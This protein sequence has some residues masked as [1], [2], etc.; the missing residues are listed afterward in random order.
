[1]SQ[2]PQWL[3]GVILKV[4]VKKLFVRRVNQISNPDISYNGYPTGDAA[5]ADNARVIRD[6]RF[7]M[8]KIGD[9]S[10]SC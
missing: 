2:L 5:L 10:E 9:E 6:N 8:Q 4:V 7:L 3:T 1:M